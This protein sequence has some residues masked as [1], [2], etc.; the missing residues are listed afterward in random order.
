MIHNNDHVKLRAVDFGGAGAKSFTA[1]VACAGAGGSIELR[2]GSTTGRLLGT[3]PV[4]GTGGATS[5]KEVTA[6]VTGATGVQDLYLVFK[7]SGT[8]ELF[9]LDHWRF[10]PVLTGIDQNRAIRPG[11]SDAFVEVRDLAGRVVRS[12]VTEATALEGLRPGV[13]LLAGRRVAVLAP[14]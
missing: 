14:R 5:W 2:V 6:T 12:R 9:N 3:L 4:V 11:P 10:T 1:S 8:G 7:G 13:Y